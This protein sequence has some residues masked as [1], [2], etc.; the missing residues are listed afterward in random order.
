MYK[1]QLEE[2]HEVAPGW[3][4][5]LPARPTVYLTLGSVV[6]LESGDL[7]ARVIAGIRELRV[8][9]IV[10]VG[11]EFDRDDLG[12]Q[13]DNVRI[14][15][16]ITQAV[17]LPSCDLV[18]SHGGSGSVIA[19][20]AHGLPL[21]VIPL[22]ADQPNNADRCDALGVGLVLDPI[23]ATADDARV[24]VQ[25]VL[26]EPAYREAALRI[27]R[28]AESLPG[29]AYAVTLLERLAIERRPML[30]G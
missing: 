6:P 7:F 23:E 26:T 5:D 25:A 1:R 28:E 17:L 22:G 13:P 2:G 18:V 12:P 20:L 4:G 30:A 8:N 29:P 11:D 3:I 24:A 16:W 9:L 19:A 10:T 27:K 21:V 15:S 14:E